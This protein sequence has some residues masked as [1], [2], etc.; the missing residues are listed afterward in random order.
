MKPGFSISILEISLS[1]N[2][3]FLIISATTKGLLLLILERTMA[4]FVDISD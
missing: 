2:N 4:A 1:S 3:F